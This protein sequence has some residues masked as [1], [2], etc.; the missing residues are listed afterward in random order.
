MEA[1]LEPV[2]QAADFPDGDGPPGFRR[3]D[4]ARG[5]DTRPTRERKRHEERSNRHFSER[6]VLN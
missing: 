6:R 4:R 3:L 2:M 1:E 5:S